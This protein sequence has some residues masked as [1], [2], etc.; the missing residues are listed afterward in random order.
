MP[1]TAKKSTSKKAGKK[2]NP[3][4]RPTKYNPSFHPRL[5]RL[6]AL[7]GMID[8]EI[9]NELGITV[10][11]LYEW[12]KKYK[13][14]SEA[15]KE[16]K[17]VIDKQVEG[18]LLQRAMGYE[19]TEVTKENIVTKDGKKLPIDKQKTIKKEVV[20]DVTAQIFWLKNRIPEEWRDAKQIDFGDIE[21]IKKKAGEIFG[22]DNL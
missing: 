14:F 13:K 22:D 7:N 12:K 2:K 15:L 9:A 5:A 8:T 11:T 6:C 10:S 19:Y 4:G 1:K 21:E 18:K 3:G 20:P 17:A 16:N